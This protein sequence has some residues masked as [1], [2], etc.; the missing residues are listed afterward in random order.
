MNITSTLFGWIVAILLGALF[1]LWRDG[2]FWKLVAY[3][4]FSCLGFWLGNLA[5][6]AMDVNFLQVGH[7]N[8]GGGILGS[9]I[10]LFLGHWV[11]LINLPSGKQG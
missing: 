10:L 1:H 11:T 4:F 2:G 7:V 8:L 5:F 6:S 3:L 9:I